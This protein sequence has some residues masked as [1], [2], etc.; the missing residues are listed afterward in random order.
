MQND[1]VEVND[2]LARSAEIEKDKLLLGTLEIIQK[3]LKEQNLQ[4]SND[5]WQIFTNELQAASLKPAVMTDDIED[6]NQSQPFENRISIEN[7]TGLEVFH[8]YL[9]KGNTNEIVAEIAEFSY[10]QDEERELLDRQSNEAEEGEIS[11]EEAIRRRMPNLGLT[12]DF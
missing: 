5:G 7:K 3:S 1:R 4:I 8:E 12:I 11:L 2:L 9:T 6:F 10:Y